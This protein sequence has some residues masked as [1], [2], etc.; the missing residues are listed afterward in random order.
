MLTMT[1]AHLRDVVALDPAWWPRTFTMKE[2]VRRASEAAP[3]TADEGLTSWLTRVAT[4]RRAA[5]LIK[6]DAGDDVA[7]PYGASRSAHDAMVHELGTLVDTLVRLGPWRR[8][9]ADA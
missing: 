5:D 8:R 4:G 3:A 2:L 9:C 1:R 7:D 6:P